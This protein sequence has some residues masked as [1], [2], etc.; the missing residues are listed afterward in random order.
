MLFKLSFLIWRFAK[1]EGIFP[2]FLICFGYST[3]S[4]S[5]LEKCVGVE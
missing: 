1:E 2:L 4:V 3:P 5:S